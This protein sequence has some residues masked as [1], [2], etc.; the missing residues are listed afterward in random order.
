MTTVILRSGATKDLIGG[1]E[2]RADGLAGSRAEF[3]MIVAQHGA[4]DIEVLQRFSAYKTMKVFVGL[5]TEAHIRLVLLE[6]RVIPLIAVLAEL[7]IQ[8]EDR[9]EHL[10][11]IGDQ[12]L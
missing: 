3:G 11:G 6:G 12:T 5:Y 8:A 10:E 1:V 9:L 2:G 7:H 4:G